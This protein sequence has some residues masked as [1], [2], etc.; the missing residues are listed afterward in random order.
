MRFD[1]VVMGGKVCSSAGIVEC[2][3]G[4]LGGKIARISK[5]PLEA[6]VTVDARGQ[7]VLPGT[8][9]V[10]F[11]S[12]DP[13]FANREDLTTG[14]RAALSGGTTTLLEMPVSV[15]PVR[16]SKTLADR[17]KALEGKS[18]VDY[19]LYGGCGT[20]R[21]DDILGQKDGGAVG[22]K[23]FLHEVPPG[24]ESMMEGLCIT[25]DVD[26]IEALRIVAKAEL[27]CSIHAEDASILK[28][29]TRML[30]EGGRK[31]PLAF[32]EACPAAAEELAVRKVLTLMK[33][34]SPRVHFAHV[35]SSSALRPIREAKGLGYDVSAETCPHYLFFTRSDL[36]RRGPYAKVS[37]PLRTREDV[38]DLWKGVRDGTIDIVASDHAPYRKEE[39]DK[40]IDDIWSAPSGLAGGE[41]LTSMVLSEFLRRRLPLPRLV[42][43]LSTNPAQRFGLSHLK[44][45]IR[46]GRDADL[47][48]I[49]PNVQWKVKAEDL[50]TRSKDGALLY[51]GLSLTGKITEVLLRGR[52]AFSEAN[53]VGK[54]GEGRFLAPLAQAG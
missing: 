7:L 9:D 31:D 50:L 51:D 34:V 26:L 17:R 13:A 33:L 8:V 42:Q 11:H 45:D 52:V 46:V 23:V 1:L 48:I 43:L 12:R 24:K 22:F 2:D 53:V 15:P 10:H 39:K 3:I 27:P 32:Y 4:I 16:D 47:T 5:L 35:S 38:D 25:N 21:E 44:G 40:G 19:C 41:L 6:D 18:H 20:L 54:P 28:Y 14:S 49:N 37:P 36:Q 30:K 29:Y